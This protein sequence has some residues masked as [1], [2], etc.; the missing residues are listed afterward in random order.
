MTGDDLT[1][2]AGTHNFR[3]LGGL[4]LRDGGSTAR[5][6][7]YRADALHGLTAAGK[8]ALAASDIG[9]IVDFRSDAER[10][11]A[12]DK[13]P[14]SRH[15]REVHLPLL[16]G[17]MSHMIKQ[18]V[19]A[20]LLGDHLAAGR[21][22]EKALENLPSLAELYASMLEHAAQPFADV[23]R[24][25]AGEEPD[26][27][28][29][30]LIHCSAGKDRTGVCAAVILDAV[31]VEREAIVADYAQSQTNLAGPWLDKME[32]MVRRMGVRI[33]PAMAE[34]M[35]GSP[36]AAI[37]AALA[38]LD[39]RGGSASYLASGGLTDDELAALRA[40]LTA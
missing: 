7:F 24:L 17:A 39:A 20:R 21:A 9:V 16:Q 30:V 13:L 25:I 4:P 3:D 8:A 38:W 37:E 22:A 34:M 23:A 2:L 12:H 5:G 26:E 35:G 6:V 31:G 33:T 29:A 1:A 40:R 14:H 28:S 11:I 18:A 32:S 10:T 19:E 36:P 15:I 27:P